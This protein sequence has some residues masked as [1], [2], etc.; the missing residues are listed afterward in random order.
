MKSSVD[1]DQRMMRGKGKREVLFARRGKE[2]RM[3]DG[4]S[5]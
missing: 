4:W 5:G 3:A 2:G 1:V